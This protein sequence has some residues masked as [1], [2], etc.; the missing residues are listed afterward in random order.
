[1]SRQWK[2]SPPGPEQLA[3]EELFENGEIADSDTPTQIQQRHPIFAQFTNR[4]F[5]THFRKTK[6]KMGGYAKVTSDQR[7][8][9]DTNIVFRNAP[10][11]TWVYVDHTRKCEIVCV[12]VAAISGSRK[13]NFCLLEDNITLNITYI[14]PS[15]IYSPEELFRSKLNPVGE[16][17]WTMD[18]PKIHSFKSR[19]IECG[20]T[21]RS[22]PE[23]LIVIKLPMKVQ[24]ESHTY[25]RSGVKTADGGNI[26]MLE[27]ESFQKEQ[28][29]EDEDT[30]I[31]FE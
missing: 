14:W 13:V 12:A 28:I 22:L 29:L 30:S 8:E 18:H 4:V 2:E 10:Y 24:R 3:L 19:L 5:Y 1:M 11:V 27:F 17:R 20:L 25:K 23:A 9:S 7:P 15:A 21:S 31:V 16:H 6:A 26:V